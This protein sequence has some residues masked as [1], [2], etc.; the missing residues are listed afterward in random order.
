MDRPATEPVTVLPGV[1]NMAGLTVDD[2]AVPFPDTTTDFVKV[3]RHH[4]LEVEYAVPRERR[5]YV[6]H[7]AFELWLPILEFTRDL[8]IGIEGG[9]LVEL[10]KTYLQPASPTE[11]D[12]HSGAED[13]G[14]TALPIA[15][16]ILHIEWHVVDRRGSRESFVA[17]GAA[18]DVLDALT[19]FE[20][21]VQD[22]ERD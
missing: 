8:L 20:Q 18:P 10:L 5:V 21:H 17:N 15:P 14:T 16:T 3:L 7:K 4:G 1:P 19:K 9:L 13:G 11:S 22:S 6:G 12:E 2:G